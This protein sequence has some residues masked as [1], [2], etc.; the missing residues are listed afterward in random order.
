MR[1]ISTKNRSTTSFIDTKDTLGG[2]IGRYCSRNR[3]V[4]RIALA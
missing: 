4:M 3:T 1:S 2:W